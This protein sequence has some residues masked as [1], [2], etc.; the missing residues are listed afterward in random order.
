[1]REALPESFMV[2]HDKEKVLK[3]TRKCHHTKFETS[4]LN[5]M[6]SKT[7]P[8]FSF[9]AIDTQLND[10]DSDYQIENNNN[11]KQANPKTK[12]NLPDAASS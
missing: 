10:N 11:N 3:L 5:Q 12:T 9:F 8:R 7:M 4:H 2:S 6:V 1:M